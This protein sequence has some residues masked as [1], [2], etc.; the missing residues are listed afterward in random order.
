MPPAFRDPSGP[1]T[2]P[3]GRLTA[4]TSV[5]RLLFP[6]LLTFYLFSPELELELEL[7][8]DLNSHIRCVSDLGVA[9][10]PLCYNSP[11]GVLAKAGCA[12]LDRIEPD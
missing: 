1:P 8:K 2:I 6:W 10:F 9:L 11:L 5:T 4:V 12:N 7:E 3:V